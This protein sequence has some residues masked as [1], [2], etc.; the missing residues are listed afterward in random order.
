MKLLISLILLSLSSS[1]FAAGREITATVNGMVCAF[2]AQGIT[3]K[4]RAEPAV[5]KVDVSLEKKTVK[6]SLKEGKDLDDKALEKILKDSG[7]NVEKITR[8]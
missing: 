8:N 1:A 2:C 3:K 6:V 5:E 7:Y 4:L